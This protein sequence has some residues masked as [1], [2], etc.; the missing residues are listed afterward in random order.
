M[1]KVNFGSIVI[2]PRLVICQ[3]ERLSVV[4]NLFQS[5][6]GEAYM[7][8]PFDGKSLRDKSPQEILNFLKEADFL[9]RKLGLPIHQGEFLINQGNL[10]GQTVPHLHLHMFLS[11]EE[12]SSVLNWGQE[13]FPSGV[14]SFLYEGELP[15]G[16]FNLYRKGEE[17][18][19][20][21]PRGNSPKKE[22]N[23]KR[24][25]IFPIIVDEQLLPEWEEKIEELRQVYHMS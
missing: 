15:S 7:A 1:E 14:S 25:G 20:V 9:F 21:V 8:I 4:V 11:R 18:W 17:N 3:T 12:G 19:T 24:E 23:P 16:Q 22:D 10:V 2:D 6:G 13:G 5:E